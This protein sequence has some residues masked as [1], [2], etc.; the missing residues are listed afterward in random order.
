ML[1]AESMRCISKNF[2]K[3]I[4]ITTFSSGLIACLVGYLSSGALVFQL[5][6]QLGLAAESTSQIIGVLCVG[7]GVITIVMSLRYKMPIMY[8]WSTPGVAVLLAGLSGQSIEQAIGIFVAAAVIT[9]AIGLSGHFDRIMKFIPEEISSALIAGILLK[10]SVNAFSAFNKMPL[11]IGVMVISYLVMRKVYSFFSVPV[12]LIVGLIILSLTNGLDIQSIDY[13]IYSPKFWIPEFRFQ[14]MIGLALPLCIVTM[15]SQNVTGYAVLRSNGY[16]I[17]GSKLVTWAGIAHLLVAPFGGFC[18]NLSSLTAAIVAGPDSHPDK[19]KRYTGAVSS[20]FVYIIM[21]LFAS[22]F[23]GLMGAV[24]VS[25]VVAIGG[26]A[27]VSVVAVNLE[28]IFSS[29]NMKE[30]AL[31]TFLVAASDFSVFGIGS[32]FWSLVVGLIV[33]QIAKIVHK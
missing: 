20:G 32:A 17:S 33:Y 1:Y 27:L 24:P 22:A 28:K 29:E 9:I 12:S 31:F 11:V 14:D 23:A 30:S 6:R 3:D 19:N 16:H 25:M 10:F 8:A 15:T 5:A 26:L 18:L 4:S 13:H 7:M 21:G 2:C